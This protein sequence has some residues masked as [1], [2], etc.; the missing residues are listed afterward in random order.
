MSEPNTNK[1]DEKSYKLIS[2]G[3]GSLTASVGWGYILAILLMLFILMILLPKA[4]GPSPW[5]AV[6]FQKGILEMFANFRLLDELADLS[7]VKVADVGE[8]LLKVDLDLV[9]VSNRKFGWAPFSI[10]ILFVGL[11]LFLRGIRQRFLAGYFGIRFVQSQDI[12][13]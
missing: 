8:G 11:A 6:A 5:D 9:G 12:P 13:F 7:I 2:D 4:E 3:R 1:D 10:A